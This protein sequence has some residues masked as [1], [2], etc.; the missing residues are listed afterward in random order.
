M[1]SL[2]HPQTNVQ[3]DHLNSTLLNML[4]TSSPGQKKDWKAYMPM[5]VCVHKCTKNVTTGYSP[6]FLVYGWE[7]RL[8]TDVEFGL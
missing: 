6:Y 5:L 1:T 8:S 7:P 4:G 3:C 2:Y